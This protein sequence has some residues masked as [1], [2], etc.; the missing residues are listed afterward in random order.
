M[1][2]VNTSGLKGV[3]TIMDAQFSQLPSQEDQGFAF[4]QEYETSEGAVSIASGYRGLHG[5]GTTTT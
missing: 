1:Y 5:P 2:F 3:A 4:A